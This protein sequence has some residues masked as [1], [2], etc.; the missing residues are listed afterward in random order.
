[1]LGQHRIG[2]KQSGFGELTSATTRPSETNRQH[3]FTSHINM[4]R[5]ISDL[6]AR[7]QTVAGHRAFA[8]QPANAQTWAA[9]AAANSLGAKEDD[10]ILQRRQRQR[11]RG[12]KAKPQKWPKRVLFCRRGSCYTQIIRRLAQKRRRQKGLLPQQ[13][14]E[15]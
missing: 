14:E 9:G 3:A 6:K 12:Q 7:H 10:I 8:H 11:R 1:M 5:Q 2:D 4:V 15:R 13:N